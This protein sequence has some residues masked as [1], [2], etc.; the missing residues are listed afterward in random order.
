MAPDRRHDRESLDA[1][2][3]AIDPS[4]SR[5]RGFVMNPGPVVIY[6]V[7]DDAAVRRGIEQLLEAHGMSVMSFPNAQAYLS[8]ARSDSAACLLLDLEL[9]GI[10]GL[11]LQE[12]LN[13]GEG[14]PIVFISGRSDVARTVR[15]MKAG[16]TEFLTKPVDPAQL[17]SAVEAALAQDRRNRARN[18]DL[19]IL[20]SRFEMLTPR[21]RQVF[22]L[23][24]A[25]LRNKQAAAILGISEIT[26]QVHRGQIMRKMCAPSFAELVRM[27]ALLGID[28]RPDGN[29]RD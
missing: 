17:L 11:D 2:S 23:I 19:S 3:G 18:A 24:L 14:P 8:H 13:A 21:E 1:S 6:L 20:Q 7:D 16:A 4:T 27:G 25:G 28:S 9:P 26:L 15:A 22:P 12:R 5:R 10:D 29:E